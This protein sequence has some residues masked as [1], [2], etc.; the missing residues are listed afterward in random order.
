MLGDLQKMGVSAHTVPQ[1]MSMCVNVSIDYKLIHKGD[2]L[3]DRKD[4]R[5][6][7]KQS[8]V[9]FSNMLCKRAFGKR[10]LI[11]SEIIEQGHYRVT[12]IA[13]FNIQ[14]DSNKDLYFIKKYTNINEKIFSLAVEET[15]CNI[16]LSF[17]LKRYV[18]DLK[19]ENGIDEDIV[20]PF[21]REMT[22]Y[23]CAYAINKYGE[24]VK[25]LLKELGYLDKDL[26]DVIVKV[27]EREKEKEKNKK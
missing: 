15:D 21:C 27:R 2:N 11:S 18:D 22:D 13:D 4:L 6:V 5:H 26:S 9:R 24:R 25:P 3:L 20:M 7:N 8:Y 10:F 19:K 14:A 16:P 1:A 12:G 17:D 23:E